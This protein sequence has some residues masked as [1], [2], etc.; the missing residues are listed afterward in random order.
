MAAHKVPG[1][2]KTAHLRA[3]PPFH[4]F[5]WMGIFLVHFL[6]KEK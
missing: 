3:G 5:P 4:V 6:E 2:S 1:G